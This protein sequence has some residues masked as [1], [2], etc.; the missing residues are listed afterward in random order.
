MRTRFHHWTKVIECYR[1]KYEQLKHFYSLLK[2]Q[3]SLKRKRATFYN[4]CRLAESRYRMLYRTATSAATNAIYC[5]SECIS[6]LY[7]HM[8]QSSRHSELLFSVNA[9]LRELMQSEKYHCHLFFVNNSQQVIE[10]VKEGRDLRLSRSMD[11]HVASQGSIP[12]SQLHYAASKT[13][14][15][16]DKNRA[17]SARSVASA[18]DKYA[19]YEVETLLMGQTRLGQ[20]A[21]TRVSAYYYT[22]EH[23]AKQ[24]RAQPSD[25]PALVFVPLLQ[26]SL[27]FA[28]S[29]QCVAVVKFTSKRFDSLNSIEYT[30]G[31]NHRQMARKMDSSLVLHACMALELS[32][33]V[34]PPLMI[35]LE[36]MRR[37]CILYDRHDY[38]QDASPTNLHPNPEPSLHKSSSPSNEAPIFRPFSPAE[39]RS[40]SPLSLHSPRPVSPI[41]IHS[42]LLTT[43]E[44][45]RSSEQRVGELQRSAVQQAEAMRK[46][47]QSRAR[48][49]DR[50]IKK[51]EELAK[52]RKQIRDQEKKGEHLRLKLKT[53]QETL[54]YLS[55]IASPCRI[56]EAMLT[57]S[58]RDRSYEQ[59]AKELDNLNKVL[60]SAASL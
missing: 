38:L 23:L 26:Q 46:V 29:T 7:A 34:I 48:H 3:Y 15:S 28:N 13:L 16:T 47:E 27:E 10:G 32:A 21:Q 58:L 40:S 8:L 2:K 5:G 20:C 50:A 4:W 53:M 6:Q 14:F 59:Q 17:E 54:R 39:E 55:I 43:L 31:L 33:A 25:L 41:G 42:Q 11:A 18:R 56:V 45:L 52:A 9:H 19:D 35:V 57:Y 24:S 36:Q 49:R 37:I 51:D 30:V 44:A 22:T 1:R 12:L 60:R